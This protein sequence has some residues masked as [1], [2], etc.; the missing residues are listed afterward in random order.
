MLKITYALLYGFLYI[1]FYV[2]CPRG[3]E[4]QQQGYFT[5]QFLRGANSTPLVFTVFGA[6]NYC[7]VYQNL[8]AV[9]TIHYS[10]DAQ[11]LPSYSFSSYNDTGSPC[12]L[13]NFANAFSVTIPLLAEKSEWFVVK[14]LMYLVKGFYKLLAQ[15]IKAV[16]VSARVKSPPIASMATVQITSESERAVAAD[17]VPLS[18]TMRR[19]SLSQIKEGMVE[20]CKNKLEALASSPPVSR[21]TIFLRSKLKLPVDPNFHKKLKASLIE[22][23]L[24]C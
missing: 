7:G 20:D 14:V 13:E 1:S 4:A 24:C 2:T 17:P 5:H 22:L 18:K 16:P 6:P 3:H 12:V 9:M 10:S 21:F 23:K 19:K 11:G 15:G 8:A